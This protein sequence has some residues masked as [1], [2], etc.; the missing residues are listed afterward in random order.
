[1]HFYQVLSNEYNSTPIYCSVL[2][3][4]S[5]NCFG[6]GSGLYQNVSDFSLFVLVIGPL[7]LIYCMK[8]YLLHKKKYKTVSND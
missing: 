2:W 3:Y 7:L 5:G 4:G 8:F 1:L 6:N